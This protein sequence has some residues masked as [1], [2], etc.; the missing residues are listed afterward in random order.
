V[1]QLTRFGFD[2]S[3]L[4]RRPGRFLFKVV[5][6]SG[7]LQVRFHLDRVTGTR[8]RDVSPSVTQGGWLDEIELAPGEY[9]L[10]EANHP[11]WNCRISITG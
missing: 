11:D 9:I 6:R 4:Q 8:L 3:E 2:Q 5:N 1:L 7:S 10:S